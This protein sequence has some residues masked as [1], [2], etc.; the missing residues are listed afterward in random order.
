LLTA[1]ERNVCFGA[2]LDSV[3]DTVMESVVDTPAE[4]P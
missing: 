4:A 2:D 3:V 1:A